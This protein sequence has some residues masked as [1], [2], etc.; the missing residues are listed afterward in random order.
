M[1]EIEMKMMED[2]NVE[3]GPEDMPLLL[4]VLSK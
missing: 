4:E 1:G 3:E 2:I